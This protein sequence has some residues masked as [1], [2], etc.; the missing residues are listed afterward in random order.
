MEVG[1]LTS[2]GLRGGWNGLIRCTSHRWRCPRCLTC[3]T[4]IYVTVFGG[5]GL[6]VRL[7]A[8]HGYSWG[9][10]IL[11]WR[12]GG[13]DAMSGALHVRRVLWRITCSSSKPPQ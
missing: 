2:A 4:S 11:I 8:Q 5:V 12:V 9:E 3:S 13:G 7:P 6:C 1:A 10:L